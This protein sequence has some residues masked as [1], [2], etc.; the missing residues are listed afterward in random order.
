MAAG[1]SVGVGGGGDGREG[2]LDGTATSGGGEINNGSD[3]FSNFENQIE[4]GD[5]GV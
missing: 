2:Q 1:A 4:G 5:G 3:C